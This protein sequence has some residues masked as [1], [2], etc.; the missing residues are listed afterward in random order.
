LAEKARDALAGLPER[1]KAD[2]RAIKA[3]AVIEALARLE[4]DD[5]VEFELILKDIKKAA[6]V[7]AGTIKKLT[8]DFKAKAESEPQ[9]APEDPTIKEKALA[10]A[11]RGDPLKYL[12]WQAQRNHLGD[13]DYQKVLLLSIA[14][15]ASETSHGIQ[16]GGN[17][18]KGSGKSDACDATYH[19]IPR[20]AA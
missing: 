11:T 5:P 3:L 7:T 1:L 12:I 13:I 8:A 16:P 17:G 19:L 2:P 20:I 14:S 10:I 4:S 9:K 18:E 6:G 15:A